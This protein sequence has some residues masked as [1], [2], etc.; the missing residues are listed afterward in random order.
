M[1]QG[2]VQ[3]PELQ[4]NVRL[5][6]APMQSDTYAPPPRPVENNNLA[7]LADALGSFSTS[8]GQIALLGNRK[9]PEQKQKEQWAAERK[10]N[11]MTQADIR[12]HIDEGGL[13]VEADVGAQAAARNI[14]GTAYGAEVSQTVR[15][16]LMSEFDW[17]KGD[18]NAY[19]NEQFAA[20]PKENLDDPNFGAAV[21][22][23]RDATVNWALDYA[24]KRRSG[25]VV[26]ERKDAAFV[27]LTGLT[28]KWV[29]ENRKPEEIAQLQ[30]KAYT[31]YGKDGVLGVNYDDLDEERLT[32]ARKLAATNP[33][34]AAA[35]LT[36]TRKGRGGQDISLSGSDAHKDDVY[37]INGQIAKSRIRI[38]NEAKIAEVQSVNKQLFNEG[39]AGMIQDFD[40]TDENGTK[41]TLTAKEQR[42]QFSKDY[43]RESRV[44]AGSMREDGNETDDRE[45][46]K[47]SQNNMQHPLFKAQ[48]DGLAAAT[49]NTTLADPNAK[50][51]LLERLKAARKI[52]EQSPNA[53]SAYGDDKDR[54]IADDF[55]AMKQGHHADGTPWSDDDALRATIQL[56]SPGNKGGLPRVDFDKL[57]GQLDE[58][59]VNKW[60]GTVG[61]KPNMVSTVRN[62]LYNQINR[63]VGT[64]MSVDD[65]TKT[66]VSEMKSNTFPY[67]GTLLHFDGMVV[68]N[69]PD[70]A[71]DF[72]IDKFAKDNAAALDAQHLGADD[73]TIQPMGSRSLFRLVDSTGVPVHDKDG[74]SR[75]ISLDQVRQWTN[76]E[77]KRQADE[78]R[79]KANFDASAA[80]RG[81]VEAIGDGGKS[82]WVNPKTRQIFRPEYGKDETATPSWTPTGER[83]KRAIITRT[84]NPVYNGVNSAVRGIKDVN[85][86]NLQ[87]EQQN[88]DSLKRFGKTI[89]DMLPGVEIG[90][91]DFSGALNK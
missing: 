41:Q 31:D 60:F 22:R 15:E 11:G 40:Y 63:Y 66:A 6:P 55:W 13:P 56:N 43:I 29:D 52:R 62:D 77:Q 53:Y 88:R 91:P 10:W 36:A 26:Q 85:G 82:V 2:R 61:M 34:V 14:T 65:A 68:P 4:S 45:I 7:R 75:Y 47:F 86:R 37:R 24:S 20:I 73:I 67:R 49:N 30:L 64:G 50:A 12:K 1:A 19:I 89:W 46:E 51:T 90:K 39:A 38:S 81:L 79:K 28:A 18:P 59:G 17:D 70:K 84:D 21:L 27:G 78:T 72:F 74:H 58:L 9:T 57:D 54:Q 87:M 71:F 33:D 69:N 32:I 25:Q 23:A 80:S 42:E 3:T 44:R 76:S 16:H 5:T 48:I 8:V 83:Y 35:I